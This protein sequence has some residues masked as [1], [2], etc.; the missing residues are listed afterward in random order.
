MDKIPA[1]VARKL[2]YYVYLL[3]D[4]RS[5]RPFYVGKGKG[6]RLLDHLS[7]VSKSRKRAVLNELDRLR[8]PPTFEILAH[9]LADE[10]T[11]FRIEAAVIDLLGLSHL[12]NSVRGWRSVQTGRMPLAQAIAYY[13]AKPVRVSDPALLIR[14]NRLYRHDIKPIELYEITRGVWRL[15][16]RRQGA[17]FALAVFEG[18]VR[19]VYTIHSWHPA[20]STRYE[21][22]RHSD[23]NSPGRCEF[24]GEVAAHTVRERYKNRS[25]GSYFNRGQQSP[26]VYVN[27]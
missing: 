13:A 2:G 23:V 3:T 11:A 16:R 19:E 22:R 27:C 15:G 14:V 20:G 6:R 21:T 5:D 8:I 4:P 9:A 12:T 24:L 26:V 18:V 10:E 7:D 1:E 17:K 25:V